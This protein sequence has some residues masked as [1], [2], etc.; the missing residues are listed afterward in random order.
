MTTLLQLCKD[1]RRE[2][3]A[4]GTDNTVVGAAG[5]WARIV[6]WVRTAWEEIQGEAEEPG[7]EFMRKAFSFV[8]IPEQGEYAFDAAPLSL[9]DFSAWRPWS[10]RIFQSTFRDEYY[11]Q[12]LPYAVFRDTYLL[13][14]FRESYSVPNV[15][16]VS[17]TKS[18][19]LALPP[20]G[21]YT[22]SG[23]YYTTPTK[24]VDD[25][26]EPTMPERYHRAVM[27]K[28]MIHYGA[29]EAAEEVVSRGAREYQKILE[30]MQ[31][32]ELPDV[33]TARSFI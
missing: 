33:M 7:W 23:E 12:Y 17:P 9:T 16:T 21:A 1:V 13:G 19:I 20:L 31:I 11:L 30:R 2:V 14:S 26:D 5:E 25:A 15:I 29:Y 6:E 4:S 27:Y 3:G 24:L 8:T 32:S 18:L 22:V 28:A 10:F